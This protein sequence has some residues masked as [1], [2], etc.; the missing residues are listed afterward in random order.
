MVQNHLLSQC[1]GDLK[2]SKQMMN[3]IHSSAPSAAAGSAM[4]AIELMNALTPLAVMLSFLSV[5]AFVKA[6]TKTFSS[7]QQP[8]QTIGSILLIAL[9][10]A[11]LQAAFMWGGKLI[12][13]PTTIF[14]MTAILLFC[15]TTYERIM[16]LRK[17]S[18][19]YVPYTASATIIPWA[20]CAMIVWLPI[21]FE[22]HIVNFAWKFTDNKSMAKIIT[23]LSVMIFAVVISIQIITWYIILCARGNMNEK[24][25]IE[26]N[27]VAEQKGESIA[28]QL[29]DQANALVMAPGK[30]VRN[31]T[32][33]G[34]GTF[35]ILF[36]SLIATL[37]Y[38]F[39][40]W[41]FGHF[42]I[43]AYN[44]SLF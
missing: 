39:I 11:F 15:V 9:I 37:I 20:I 3:R 5:K 12:I 26:L 44:P 13:A 4:A 8:Y 30:I 33:V 43:A 2:M 28:R 18:Q 35:S 10:G 41:Y 29:V 14:L 17:A 16:A 31:A 27:R 34:G 6:I 38:S 23:D 36:Y 25:V 19:T 42:N 21:H 22:S 7:P 40:A 24:C 32:P 1:N